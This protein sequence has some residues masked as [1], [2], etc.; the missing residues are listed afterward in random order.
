MISESARRHL[1][2]T[3]ARNVNC[4]CIE[5]NFIGFYCNFRKYIGGYSLNTLRYAIIETTFNM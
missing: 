2:K 3:W 5:T 1:E 4:K